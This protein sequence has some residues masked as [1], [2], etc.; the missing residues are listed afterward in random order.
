MN[1]ISFIPHVLNVPVVYTFNLKV[2]KFDRSMI[3]LMP[4]FLRNTSFTYIYKINLKYF[5]R[6]LKM[7]DDDFFF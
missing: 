5:L 6:L 1:E 7:V 4:L 3:L 2:P